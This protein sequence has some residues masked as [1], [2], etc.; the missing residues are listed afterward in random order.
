MCKALKPDGM[1]WHQ[2]CDLTPRIFSITKNPTANPIYSSEFPLTS[3]KTNSSPSL[4]PSS[5]PHF[6]A[7][8]CKALHF[9]PIP[10]FAE[11]FLFKPGWNEADTHFIFELHLW[12]LV[13]LCWNQLS[14]AEGQGH[15]V[16]CGCLGLSNK[17]RFFSEG[18]YPVYS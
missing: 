5:P 18:Q 16:L 4:L 1:C 14:P 12:G 6:Q 8:I 9:H 17:K 15:S 2:G 11:V 7:D 13:F 3:I 10:A